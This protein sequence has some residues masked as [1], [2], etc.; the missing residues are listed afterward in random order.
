M[1]RPHFQPR[2]THSK[3]SPADDVPQLLS[4]CLYPPVVSSSAQELIDGH[5]GELYLN[6]KGREVVN[7]SSSRD[8]LPILLVHELHA[9][10]FS[11]GLQYCHA[12]VIPQRDWC[13]PLDHHRMTCHLIIQSILLRYPLEADPFVLNV[14][15]S[16]AKIGELHHLMF[17]VHQC[18]QISSSASHSVAQY[19]QLHQ[20]RSQ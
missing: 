16:W 11:L 7:F 14:T 18:R 1:H 10:E 20:P 17:L 3:P 4:P 2:L 15:F 5:R 8:L 12:W 13:L 6:S 19:L 9:F